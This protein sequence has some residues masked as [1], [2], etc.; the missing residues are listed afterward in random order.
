MFR[1]TWFEFGQIAQPNCRPKSERA[2]RDFVCGNFEKIEIQRGFGAI[3]ETRHAIVHKHFPR[4]ES[5]ILASVY[6]LIFIKEDFWDKSFNLNLQQTQEDRLQWTVGRLKGAFRNPAYSHSLDQFALAIKDQSSKTTSVKLE[7]TNMREHLRKMQKQLKN[8]L[9]SENP[10]V[11]SVLS[12]IRL[13]KL[14]LKKYRASVILLNTFVNFEGK[15]PDDL[16][17]VTKRYFAEHINVSEFRNFFNKTDFRENVRRLLIE[18]D[19]RIEFEI[20]WKVFID[21]FEKVLLKSKF[22]RIWLEKNTENHT[23]HFDGNVFKDLDKRYNTVE[24]VEILSGYFKH[25]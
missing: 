13:S 15:M 5:V 9:K 25:V 24:L 4:K 2:Q 17:E 3:A 18:K 10:D 1:I 20:I 21:N 14:S 7:K 8:E 16:I 22:I 12:I 19:L 6:F 11:K 23:N